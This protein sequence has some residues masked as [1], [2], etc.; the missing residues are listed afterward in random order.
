VINMNSFQFVYIVSLVFMGFAFIRRKKEA[1]NA[2]TDGFKTNRGS[3]ISGESIIY[4]VEINNELP[5]VV[6]DVTVSLKAYPKNCMNFTGQEKK[7]IKMIRPDKSEKLE[8]RFI[9]TKDYVDGR[10]QTSVSYIDSNDKLRTVHLEPFVIRS[11]CDLL[12]PIKIPVQQF[13]LLL[14]RMDAIN[15]NVNLKVQAESLFEIAQ[16]LFSVKNFH[17]IDT[18]KFVK[19]GLFTGAIRGYA[20]G[21]YTNKKV[22]LIFTVKGASN[23]DQAVVQV[24][25]H[26]DDLAMLHT[27][28]NEVVSEIR[29]I[30]KIPTNRQLTRYQQKIE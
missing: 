9:P 16:A 20:E 2:L 6:N 14:S 29:E 7:T 27:A 26:G 21:K 30:R 15:E 3:V 23:I 1:E 19:N 22:A 13:D 12:N 5:F 11:V 4:K 28:V 10:I 25:A 17:I 8:F 24:Q 18:E